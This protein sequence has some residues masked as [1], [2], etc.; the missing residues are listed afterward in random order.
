[1][2]TFSAHACRWRRFGDWSTEYAA[3]AFASK[4][5][6]SQIHADGTLN[7]IAAATPSKPNGIA[8]SR[9]N[10]EVHKQQGKNHRNVNNIAASRVDI[11]V[12]A[13]TWEG[14]P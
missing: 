14:S 1:M 6:A 4:L 3:T 7:S 5:N 13:A 9:A 2:K 11:A 12:E 8:A 10:M